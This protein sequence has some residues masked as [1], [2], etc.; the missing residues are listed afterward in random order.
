M[1]AKI[2]ILVLFAGMVLSKPALDHQ[3]QERD[4]ETGDLSCYECAAATNPNEECVQESKICGGRGM[5]CFYRGAKSPNGHMLFLK[6]CMKLSR[7][8]DEAANNSD[9]CSLDMNPDSLAT[10]DKCFYCSEGSLSNDQSLEVLPVDCYNC[11]WTTDPSQCDESVTCGR[12]GE[13]CAFKARKISNGNMEYWKGCLWRTT[14]LNQANMD[15]DVCPEGADDFSGI[16]KNERCNYCTEGSLSNTQ[17]FSSA[18]AE[19]T[20]PLDEPTEPLDAPAEPTNAPGLPT[21]AVTEPTNTSAEPIEASDDSLNCYTC[22]KAT[23][24]LTECMTET[25]EC[26]RA[27]SVCFYKGRKQPNGH[28]LY[29][30]GCMRGGRCDSAAAE[31]SPSC[32]VD[33]NPDDMEVNEECVFCSEGTQSN[34]QSTE[35]LPVDCYN[36]DWTNDAEECQETITCD[37]VGEICAFKAKRTPSGDVQYLKGCAWRLTCQDTNSDNP[38][39][40]PE[41]ADDFSSIV[42][43][44]MC[45]Y[46][47]E[48]SLSNSQV[49]PEVVPP[50]TEAPTLITEAPLPTTVAPVP[51][52]EA[53]V[54]NETL[55]CY[56]CSQSTN[57]LEECTT[58][59]E[60]CSNGDVCYFKAKKRSSGDIYYSKG[61]MGEGRCT[62][63]AASNPESCGDMSTDTIGEG[64]ECFCCSAGSLSNDQAPSDVVPTAEPTDAPEEPTVPVELLVAADA[65]PTYAPEETTDES[66]EETLSC[67]KCKRSTNPAED[68]L[69]E[70]EECKNSDDFLCYM[71]GKKRRN[72]NIYFS[73]GCMK[74]QRCRQKR[75]DNPDSCEDMLSN[76]DSVNSGDECYFCS[77]KSLSNDKVPDFLQDLGLLPITEAPEVE[78]NGTESLPDLGLAAD[79][80]PTTDVPEVEPTVTES[81]SQSEEENISCYKCKKSTN[82][83]ADCLGDTEECRNSDFLCYMRGKK[84]RN[85]DIYY[86]KGCMKKQDCRQKRRDNPDSCEDMLSNPDSVNSGDECYFCSQKSLS[87]D[88]VPVSLPDSL[89]AGTESLPALAADEP[90]VE[91]DDGPCIL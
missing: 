11:D 57:P 56:S 66:V 30:K 34:D 79:Q 51:T 41:G 50:T 74:K 67:Y 17:S 65:V 12:T 83:A 91:P 20:E 69:G 46:C 48:D 54:V 14:C 58:D 24:P 43:R 73:K 86:S 90:G 77:Q 82:P 70:T 37:R 88:K 75:R 18:P 47:T 23:N 5:A 29:T 33:M 1:I 68:C 13:I 59:T 22:E 8:Q 4:E 28:L 60:E 49:L 38:E 53:P 87:N 89:P 36:C 27:G 81:S 26:T 25:L 52:T 61:C 84:R 45:M 15:P 32:S 31:N 9:G 55:S 21:E 40:C 72:G 42:E 6:G 76:P 19:P 44:E 35:V 63:N 85:G 2:P 3:I 71:K 39:T 78:P 62:E 16:D 64:D 80:L 10:E 7:C